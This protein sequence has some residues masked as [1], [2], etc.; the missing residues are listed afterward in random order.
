[1]RTLIKR[2]ATAIFE[3]KNLFFSSNFQLNQMFY[4]FILNALNKTK[5]KQK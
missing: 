2:T 3:M 5:N 1:M 4:S